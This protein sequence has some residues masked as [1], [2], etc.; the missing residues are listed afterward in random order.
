MVCFGED[1]DDLDVLFP[2]FSPELLIDAGSW[3]AHLQQLKDDRD[4]LKQFVEIGDVL[5]DEVIL[6]LGQISRL[7]FQ[8]DQSVL[9]LIE[10]K[11]LR[12]NILW[13]GFACLFEYLL[14]EWEHVGQVVR[15]CLTLVLEALSFQFLG[16]LLDALVMLLDFLL[17]LVLD[18]ECPALGGTALRLVREL[19]HSISILYFNNRPHPLLTII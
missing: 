13:V 15:A 2:A 12:C 3:V 19:H 6:G 17:Y 1:G 11:S 9:A 8:I 5:L 4:I 18:L 10:G 7:V 16:F 14:F